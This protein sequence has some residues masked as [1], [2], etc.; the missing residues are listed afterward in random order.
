MRQATIK[1]KD[2][3]RSPSV[4]VTAA[5]VDHKSWNVSGFSSPSSVHS[6]PVLI[7]VTLYS[8]D[9]RKFMATRTVAWPELGFMGVGVKPEGSLW[10]D[11]QHGSTFISPL[12]TRFLEFVSAALGSRWH[13]KNQ[14]STRV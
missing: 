10:M 9:Q 8:P 3:R 5:G 6:N 14:Q 7:P 2:A 13:L 1:L 11:I 12:K 4:A